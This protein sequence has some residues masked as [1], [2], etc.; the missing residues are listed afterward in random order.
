MRCN[1]LRK[2]LFFRL[3]HCLLHIAN[4]FYSRH[5]EVLAVV[6]QE[7]VLWVQLDDFVTCMPYAIKLSNQARYIKTAELTNRADLAVL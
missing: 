5:Y 4:L 2:G 7:M 3:L 6:Q 1:H